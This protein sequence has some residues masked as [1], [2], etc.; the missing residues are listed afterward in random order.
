MEPGQKIRNINHYYE[1]ISEKLQWDSRNVRE[2]CACAKITLG[3]LAAI[4]RMTDKSLAQK[5]RRGF[6]KQESLLLH[7]IAV[8]YQYHSR[9]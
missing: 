4:L 2:L 8:R 6:N 5:L 9:T 7:F 3:E 1:L